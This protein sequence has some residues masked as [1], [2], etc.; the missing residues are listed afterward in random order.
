M[1]QRWIPED[2]E[3]WLL[4][5]LTGNYRHLNQ[6]LFGGMLRGALIELM[7]DRRY[8]GRWVPAAS[9]IQLQRNFA[10]TAPWL[11]TVEVLKHEMAHQFVDQVLGTA[12]HEPPHGPTFQ[13][14][15]RE[16]GIDQRASGE[17]LPERHV[18]TAMRRIEKLL[19]LGAS[20]EKHEAELAMSKAQAILRS[21]NLSE[22]DARSAEAFSFRQIG[23]PALRT[24][25]HEKWISSILI[26]HFFVDLV[27]VPAPVF[28]KGRLGS[29][30]EASGTPDNLDIAE[31]VHAFLLNTGERL[32]R[33]HQERNEAPGRNRLRFLNGVMM[34]FAEKLNRAQDEA[35]PAERALVARGDPE[36]RAYT[37]R[38]HPHTRRGTSRGIIEDE[39]VAAGRAA[40]QQIVLHKGV[41]SAGEASGR[42]LS[43]GSDKP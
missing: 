42:A 14:V 22:I 16:R 39:V 38:R 37:N 17:P 34:G 33:A 8:L 10:C 1:L 29:V 26:T 36:H 30:L 25:S 4:H 15:C 41:S 12:S 9:S 31:Y 40:G 43:A 32:W 13:R 28:G 7:D 27:R 11:E 18:S 5:A 23:V 2:E 20:S 3:P 6:T 24:K 35:S 21:H 19:A